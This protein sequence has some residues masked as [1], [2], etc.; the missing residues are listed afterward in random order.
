M[1]N[2]KWFTFSDVFYLTGQSP[3]DISPV[4]AVCE[5]AI[6]RFGWAATVRHNGRILRA[7]AT[8]ERGMQER[9]TDNAQP[10]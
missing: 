6:C 4:R 3:E 1:P 2:G 9:E 8:M 7:C 5:Q 10:H